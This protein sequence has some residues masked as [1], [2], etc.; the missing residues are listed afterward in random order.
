MLIGSYPS[1][2]QQIIGFCIVTIWL[3]DHYANGI[4]IRKEKESSFHSP[5]PPRSGTAGLQNQQ[6]YLHR[7][8]RVHSV[9]SPCRT[10]QGWSVL[11]PEVLLL[12]WL[13]SRHPSIQCDTDTHLKYGA[14]SQW[15]NSLDRVLWFTLQLLAAHHPDSDVCTWLI[16]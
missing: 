7:R 9:C 13:S 10:G 2:V 6:T 4:N 11:P 5:L 1:T 3:I 16:T 12:H 15:T 14:R 8:R